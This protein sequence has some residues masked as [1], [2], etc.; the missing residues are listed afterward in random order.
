MAI[1]APS[2]C[3]DPVTSAFLP[4]RLNKSRIPINLLLNFHTVI[5]PVGQN[6]WRSF[7][8]P[9]LAPN[10]SISIGP[11]GTFFALITVTPGTAIAP[12]DNIEKRP[13]SC[14]NPPKMFKSG[15]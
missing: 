8:V 1:P 11:R 14:K 6:S 2:P 13:S 10:R 12:G 5:R 9:C 7:N 4:F 3:P 15:D